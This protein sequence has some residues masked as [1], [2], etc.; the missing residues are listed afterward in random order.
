MCLKT[1]PL[2]LIEP[3]GEPTKLESG[4]YLLVSK[5]TV[6]S[7]SLGVV[8]SCSGAHVCLTVIGPT[9]VAD[10]KRAFDVVEE[11]L[12]PALEAKAQ[13]ISSHRSFSL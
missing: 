9:E 2:D 6:K 12:V 10:L 11:N 3:A 8:I 13:A 4:T 5:K 7:I 1:R